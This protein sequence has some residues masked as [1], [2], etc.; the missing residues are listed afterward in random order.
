MILFTENVDLHLNTKG[1][2]SFIEIPNSTY[3][4][5]TPQVNHKYPQLANSVS[6]V[7]D[8]SFITTKSQENLGIQKPQLSNVPGKISPSSTRQASRS[9]FEMKAPTVS[10]S[11]DRVVD[12]SMPQRSYTRPSLISTIHSHPPKITSSTHTAKNIMMPKISYNI[13]SSMKA[14]TRTTRSVPKLDSQ[15]YARSPVSPMPRQQDFK[16]PG[17]STNDLRYYI[18]MYGVLLLENHRYSRPIHVHVLLF[19]NLPFTD[20]V[21][22]TPSPQHPTHFPLL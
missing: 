22:R 20:S 4:K 19:I 14:T 21:Y 2:K 6:T 18:Y 10:Q 16:Q 15:Q 3:T 11:V 7:R 12:R 9:I 1:D 17:L 8:T 13:P 5:Q